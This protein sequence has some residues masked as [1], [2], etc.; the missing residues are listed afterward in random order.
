MLAIATVPP[1]VDQLQLN[2]F[3]YRQGLVDACR[4]RGLAIEAYSPLT[5][6]RDLADPVIAGVAERVGRTPAQV[7]LRWGIQKGF[8]VIPKSNHLE[9]QI[10]N[11]AIFDFTLSAADVAELDALDRTGGSDRAHETPWW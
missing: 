8:V 5:R 7:M 1:A 6:G 4:T 10:E 3:A 9:R 2:P 11:A